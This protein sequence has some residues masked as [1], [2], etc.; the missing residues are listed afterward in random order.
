MSQK[1]LCRENTPSQMFIHPLMSVCP[2]IFN[3]FTFKHSS[4]FSLKLKPFFWFY[5]EDYKQRAKNGVCTYVGF[6][7]E[8]DCIAA[9]LDVAPLN[10][11]VLQCNKDFI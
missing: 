6:S 7:V 3:M 5:A 8:Q 1:A 11:L 2:V 10:M 4:S 9:I